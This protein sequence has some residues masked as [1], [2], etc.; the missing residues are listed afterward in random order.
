MDTNTQQQN[1]GRDSFSILETID[2]HTEERKVL[3]EF[4]Y[5]D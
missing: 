2:I 1:T 4:D 3:R 5:S